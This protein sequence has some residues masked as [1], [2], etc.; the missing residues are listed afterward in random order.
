MLIE[1]PVA[2]AEP[3]VGSMKIFLGLNR[4]VAVGLYQVVV[5][6]LLSF[7]AACNNGLFLYLN[8]FVQIVLIKYCVSC[9]P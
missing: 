7:L 2:N 4:N 6:R 5:R 1:P 9:V 3:Y 8:G